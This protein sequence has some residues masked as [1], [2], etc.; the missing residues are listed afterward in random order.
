[1]HKFG[2]TG[3]QKQEQRLWERERAI[4]LGAKVILACFVLRGDPALTVEEGD[5]H[6]GVLTLL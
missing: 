1:M 3:Y 2:I 4:M 5:K 6:C